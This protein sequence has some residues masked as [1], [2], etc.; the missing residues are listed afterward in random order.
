MFDPIDTGIVP[1]K[2][3][4]TATLRAGNTVYS[5]HIPKD[6]LTGA[7]VQGDIEAQARQALRNLDQAMRAAGGS[8]ANVVYMAIYLVDRAD[9][10][11]MNAI[12][13]EF[14]KPP[15]P[16]RVTVVV[17]ELLSPGVRI[18]FVATAVLET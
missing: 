14:F 7:I 3:P 17:K 4:V 10:A 11:G 5:A 1:P 2:G 9:A 6:P 8:L 15:Y 12:Y 13:T 18:E 16:C